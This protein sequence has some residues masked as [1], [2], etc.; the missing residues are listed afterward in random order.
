MSFLVKDKQQGI[1]CKIVEE[2]E[3]LET[4]ARHRCKH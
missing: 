3:L 2:G 4:L 1:I